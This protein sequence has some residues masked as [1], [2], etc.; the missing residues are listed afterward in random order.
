MAS[1]ARQIASI[2]GSQGIAVYFTIIPSKEMA[3]QGR[4]EQEQLAA[5][6][7]YQQAV[8]AE[9][10]RIAWLETQIRA[11][12]TA[13]FIDVAGPLSEAVRGA[14]RLFPE[15][16]DGHPVSAGY[17]VIAR[18]LVSALASELPAPPSGL[19]ISQTGNDVAVPLF[20]RSG[21]YWL[22]NGDYR[23]LLAEFPSTQ[24]QELN[25]ESMVMMGRVT[26]DQVREILAGEQA[27]T[28]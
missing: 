16:L 24:V 7:A 26:T 20:V 23:P 21:Q 9:A 17:S 12:G 6:A 15:S 22:V 14:G 1:A 28:Q 2:A 19:V 11:L 8:M 27:A 18:E 5:P 3:Y 25:L 4:V 10:E 13:Q